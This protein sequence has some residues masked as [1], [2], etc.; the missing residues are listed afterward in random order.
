VSFS[1]VQFTSHWPADDGAGL[2]WQQNARE[3]FLGAK[4][5]ADLYHEFDQPVFIYSK[6]L[7]D[8]RVEK[9]RQILPH[10]CALSY[11][12]KAN[13][14]APLVAH[15][16]ALVDGA[17]VASQGELALA[18][19][20]GFSPETISFA[21]PGKTEAEILY[22]LQQGV[23]ITAESLRQVENIAKLAPLKKDRATKIALRVNPSYELRASGMR[24]GGGPSPFGIDE[25]HVPEA[26]RIAQSLGLSVVGLHFYAGSQN[27]DATLIATGIDQTGPVATRLI[28]DHLSREHQP[29]PFEWLNIGGG[30]GVPYFAGEKPLDLNPIRDA[31]QRCAEAIKPMGAQLKIELGRYL[32]ADAGVYCCKVIDIKTSRAALYLV[33]NGGLHHHQAACG[34]FGQVIKRP[35]PIALSSQRTLED[36]SAHLKTTLVGPLCTPMDT[37][38]K[39]LLLPPAQVGDLVVVFRSGAYGPSASPRDFLGHSHSEEILI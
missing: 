29:C 31:L 17:D 30:L 34:N 15:M 2:G 39:D 38:A 22:A 16:R 23:T 12:V 27:L 11:A 5:L 8:Q 7:L 4:P 9:I 37:F 18:L 10:Q 3:I 25:E 36:G 1:P 20:S 35:Y 28:K 19:R 26:I 6:A 21:G 14:Y 24:M 32:V 13:P 33:L